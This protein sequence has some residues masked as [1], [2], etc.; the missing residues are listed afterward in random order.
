LAVK[1]R[2]AS[3]EDIAE[4]AHVAV[5]TVYKH[6]EDK[7]ALISATMMFGF[8]EWLASVQASVEQ[9]TDPLEKLVLPMRAFVRTKW[10]H[11]HHS[12]NMVN[13]SDLVAKFAPILSE[14]L[15]EHI[16]ELIKAKLLTCDDPDV[17]ARNIQA[18]LFSTANYQT[19]NSDAKIAD[20]DS[21]VR[22]ALKMLGISDAKARKLTE[23]KIPK[24]S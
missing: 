23:S 11:P 24:I 5:S 18:V 12:Q 15:S 22:V 17:A 14:T 9:S 6:F 10:T 8:Y 3:I 2:A 19:I 1:G 4:H 21:S 13:F 20:G 7:D 16:K